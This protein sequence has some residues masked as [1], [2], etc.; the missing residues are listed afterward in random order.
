MPIRRRPDVIPFLP[1]LV[2]CC[3][4]TALQAAAAPP[5]A[6][7]ALVLKPRQKGVD[8]SQ[9]SAE[10]AKQATIKQEKEGGVSALVVRSPS[11]EVLRAFADSDGNRVVDRWSYYKDGVEVYREIDSDKDTKADEYRWLAGGGS[12]W[13]SDPDADGVIDAWKSLSAEEAT[14]EV[15]A[16]IRD[17]DAAAFARLLPTQADLEAAGFAGEQLAELAAR[18]AAAPAAFA[19][20]VA[21]QK[22][23]GPDSRWSSMLT[24]QPPGTLPAGTNGLTKDVTAYDNVVALVEG[25][26]GNGQVFVGS[27]VKCGDAWRPVDAPQVS[28]GAEV[29]EPFGFFMP[30]VPGRGPAAGTGDVAENLKPLLAKLRELEGAM[31]AAALAARPALAAEYVGLLEQAVVAAADTDKPFWTNQLVETIAAYVQEGLLPDGI[32]KL[33]KLAEAAKGDDTAAAFATF[34]LIQARYT[35]GMEQ[36]G[37]DGEELQKAWF[38]DLQAF[39]DAYPKAPESAEALLQL[40]FR[41]EFE[42]RDQ[43]AV[44]RYAAIASSFPDTPQARKAAGA[45][46]RLESI[47]KPLALAGST[48]DGK[49]VAV[50]DLKGVPVLVHYWSTDCE[51]CKVDLAQIRELQA[52]HGPKKFRVVGVALDGDKAKLAKFLQAKPLP[53]PQLH[54][55]G[56]LDSRLAEE[57]GVL[58][59]PTM[60]LVG[61]DGNVI[62]RNV[63][64]T[65]LEKQLDELIAGPAASP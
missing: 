38:A 26:E 4:L 35:V 60:V 46:R 36:P 2:A 29:G 49:R 62:D 58:A 8:Y 22:D 51:P 54:E 9:P 34:R 15:V 10:E 59:L 43:E 25:K 6:E 7:D 45:V 65:A 3:L 48:V 44:G 31:T 14:A 53:W 32:A 39:A 47:G 1:G 57:F 16:A 19:K 52:K 56:G 23:I 50:Q 41:D 64:I 12:R 13:A 63:S 18:V 11:G 20:V 17:R 21:A 55:P 27:L 61:A 28:G 5:T 42:G 24:P 37:F 30:R 40:A 33:E